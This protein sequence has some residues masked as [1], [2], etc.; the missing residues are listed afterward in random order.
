M[1]FK[2]IRHQVDLFS[3]IKNY[4][5][6][7]IKTNTWFCPFHNDTN[8]PNL[9]IKDNWYRCWACGEQGDVTD[10]VSR[11]ENV[12]LVQAREY[13][14]GYILD[15]GPRAKQEIEQRKQEKEIE[16]QAQLEVSQA[17][18]MKLQPTVEEYHANLPLCLDYWQRE[19]ISE[20][21]ACKFKLGYCPSCPTYYN[22]QNPTEKLPSY[23]I[24]FYHNNELI[25]L[26]HRLKD[27]RNDKY[28]PEIK[29]LPNC[30]FNLD[31]LT[32][33]SIDGFG[34]FL[35][36][37]EALIVEGE[38]KAMVLDQYGFRT[39][40]LMG[41]WTWEDEWATLFGHLSKV[42]IALDPGLKNA[43][44]A[45]RNIARPLLQMGL[46]V[47]EIMMPVKPDDFFVKHNGTF[48]DFLRFLEY[49]R[50]L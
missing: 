1:D 20:Q 7:P 10:F 32:S 36:D 35:G 29:G 28:R 5:G 23:T 44:D 22:P 38:K 24:P 47:I 14:N 2:A 12:G 21:T 43:L 8:N 15:L 33:P 16:R 40:G 17:T 49:G 4:L 9:T 41:A 45:Y 18:L 25:H 31:S 39:V 42:Y 50:P 13:M 37:S 30:L 11:M 19:G 27:K 26:R 34:D 48:Y 46:T 6:E 3:I